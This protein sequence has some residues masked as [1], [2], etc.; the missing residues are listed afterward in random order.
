MEPCGCKRPYLPD[1]AE[2]Q[3]RHDC[4]CRSIKHGMSHPGRGSRAHAGWPW[5]LRLPG[6]Q[7]PRNTTSTAGQGLPKPCSGHSRCH[8][9]QRCWEWVLGREPMGTSG[10]SFLALPHSTVG[11]PTLPAQQARPKGVAGDTAFFC[12]GHTLRDTAEEGHY[13]LKAAFSRTVTSLIHKLVW[14]APYEQEE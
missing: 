3:G 2:A 14:P 9:C 1:P 12:T 7:A 4:L 5:A 13:P 6:S 11:T 10:S 8:H